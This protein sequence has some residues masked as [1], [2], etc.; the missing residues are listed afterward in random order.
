[1]QH[2]LC[3][4]IRKNIFNY[5]EFY[6]LKNSKRV[7]KQFIRDE[8]ILQSLREFLVQYN[9]LN[10]KKPHYYTQIYYQKTAY[11]WDY[12]NITSNTRR[13]YETGNVNKI[14]IYNKKVRSVHVSRYLT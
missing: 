9:I 1:M 12:I 10:N 3:D 8:D 4:D 6:E 11:I 13:Y 5:L 2:T 14:I 7:C